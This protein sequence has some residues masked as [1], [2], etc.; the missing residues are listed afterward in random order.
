[1]GFFK[2]V[3]KPIR[4][5]AKKIIPKEV[6][7]FLPYA[8]A[9][10]PGLQGL[11]A[12]GGITNVAAQKALIAGLTAA[13]TD[14]DANI[15]RTAALAA[16][17]DVLS[18]GLGSAGRMLGDAN[19]KSKFAQYLV[20]KG[21]G[22]EAT[23]NN[24]GLMDM[25]K[26]GGAQA[27]VD[28]AAKFAEINQDEI[29][30]YNEQLRQQGV[31]SKTKRRTAIYDIYINAGYEPEYVN[32]M[33]DKYGYAEGGR[34]G[35]ASGGYRGKAER[36]L[37][38]TTMKDLLEGTPTASK[39]TK[40]DDD[41]DD[42]DDGGWKKR[43][44][45]LNSGL[46][47]AADGV[48]RAFGRSFGNEKPVPMMR[49]AEGGEVEEGIMTQISE[50]MG[51]DFDYFTRIKMRENLKQG[52]SVE[53]AA[54]LAEQEA[55]DM[56]MNKY[57]QGGGGFARGGEVIEETEDLGIMDFMKDQGVEYG[58]QASNAQ[59]DE[60]L[61]NLFEQFLDMGYSPE[62]AAKKAREAFDEMSR[63]EGITGTRVASGYK[64]DIE[65]MY[66]QYVF[67]MEEQGLEPMSFAEFLTQARANMAGGG[68]VGFRRGGYS[69]QDDMTDYATNVGREAATG[70]GWTDS[71]DNQSSVPKQWVKP[72]VKNL[73]EH[74]VKNWG[75][76]QLGL[77]QFVHPALAIKSIIDTYRGPATYN[78]LTEED[79][80]ADIKGYRTDLSKG[81]MKALNNPTHKFNIQSMGDYGILN[82]AGFKAQEIEGAPATKKD[83]DSYYAGTYVGANGG[84]VGFASG[85]IEMDYFELFEKANPQFKGMDR[86]S[87]EYR[88]Y[89][90]DY[91]GGLI[92]GEE[93]QRQPQDPH[94]DQVIEEQEEFFID[95]M[96]RPRRSQEPM[97][98]AGGGIMNR[99]LLN[100]GLDKDMRGGGF[101]PEGTKEKADDVPARLSKNEFVMTADAVRAAGGGSV[102]KGAKRMYNMMHQLEGK[103]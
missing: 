46:A 64:D 95:K 68:R 42:D 67:Q 54:N 28:Q 10:T 44:Y 80:L 11:A 101:I 34:I 78:D 63:K 21:T 86:S 56:V 52:E 66:E 97:A 16:A 47:A 50:S 24:P 12:A 74:A 6:R 89:F 18:Q 22:L 13:A 48:E 57:T 15:L 17:P 94:Q 75:I 61:E 35:Y 85:G 9:F 33:L 41:D 99:N 53:D 32:N 81:Q 23:L 90:D 5:I 72:V 84:R 77:G 40:D 98:V 49:F 3:F 76:K 62:D 100:T 26:I 43:L 103:V 14:E 38:L 65:E 71:G 83:I 31:L 92:S 30:K 55:M 69:V 58:Q 27:S 87:D 19:P 4:K 2:K 82:D 79:P 73:G 25:A 45:D 59:N 88:F 7:P 37:G 1:M 60:I 102:N 51:K 93:L 39:K 96:P 70:G 20:S 91:W 8:A 36:A 29:D